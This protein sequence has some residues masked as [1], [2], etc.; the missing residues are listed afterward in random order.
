MAMALDPILLT[1]RWP[2][3][4]PVVLATA[5]TAFVAVA[6]AGD[7]ALAVLYLLP[8]TLVALELGL[9]G[10]LVAAALAAALVIAGDPVAI[11][12]HGP[13]LV[14]AGAIAG[15][16]SDRMRAAHGRE[17]R[18]LDSGLVL[19]ELGAREPL[20]EAVAAAALRTPGVAGA[21][22]EIDGHPPAVAGRVQGRSTVTRIVAHGALLGRITVVH[23]A[24]LEAEDRVA[25]ELLALQAGLAADN[26]RLL[27]REREAA[28]LEA[29]LREQRSGLGRLLDAQE[30]DR[31][32]VADTLHEQLAQTLAAVLLGLRMLRREAGAEGRDSFDELHG[33][34]S[35]V[36]Q[37]VRDLAGELRPS[38]LAELG[39][40]PA[41]EA[42]A[43]DGGREVV[44]VADELPEPLPEPLRTGV[45]RLVEHTLDATSPRTPAT[46]SLRASG[47]CLHVDLDVQLLSAGEPLAAA[48]ARASLL[49]GSLRAEPR[50]GGRTRI[51]VRLPFST[52]VDQPCG[53]LLS[54]QTGNAA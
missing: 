23:D 13:V 15:R 54:A 37:E 44:V 29:E 25:L 20:A 41:L 14:A 40:M 8:V 46:V 45:Y 3:R 18:L 39:L 38:S 27:S 2:E 1:R 17:Q 10:G 51:R 26:Q 7:P 16:F 33:Q 50:P 48:R 42:L 52:P 11:A 24:G 21:V 43:R 32:R 4:R 47:S 9:V 53:E 5:A 30:D 12:T 19:A 28:R 6:V 22:V 36:L 49:G 35:G 34:V 31:R